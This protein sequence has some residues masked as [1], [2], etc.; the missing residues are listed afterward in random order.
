MAKTVELT[1][2]NPTEQKK[3]NGMVDEAV[4]SM[5]RVYNEKMFKK[6]LLDRVKDEIHISASD[7]NA[8]VNERYESKSTKA[9]EKH[10][11]IAEMN[12]ILRNN[13]NRQDEESVEE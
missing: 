7:F 4:S 6:D 3:L 11:A 12:E 9:V 1:D 5:E 8:L 13:A 10:E 2:L